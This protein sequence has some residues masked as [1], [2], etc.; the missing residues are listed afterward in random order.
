MIVL[1]LLNSCKDV[2]QVKLDEGSELYVIDAFLQNNYNAQAIFI[3]K[4]ST[5]FNTTEPEPVVNAQ[6][7]LYDLTANLSYKFHYVREDRYE[8]YTEDESAFTV[9]HQYKLEV[10]IDGVTYTAITTQKRPA[11]ID[12][13]SAT[14]YDKNR[15]TGQPTLPYY[16]CTLWAKDKVDLEPD[17]YWIKAGIDTSLNLCI[18]GTA[19]IVKNAGVDSLYFTAPYNLL[20][21]QTYFPGTNCYVEVHA[22]QRETYDFLNQALE[23]IQN[24]GLF[25]TTPENVKTNF[26]TPPGAKKKV[27]GW[28]SVATIAKA[29]RQ[30]PG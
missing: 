30:I 20:Q 13:I 6:V 7:T 15:I 9:G 2:V 23:Q 1:C 21:F 4:N 14:Y 12:S 11:K 10:I 18:D 29:N 25:A 16:M 5:Y 26:I 3:H 17:Y 19:G 8:I 27:V 22:I 28:F 24:G